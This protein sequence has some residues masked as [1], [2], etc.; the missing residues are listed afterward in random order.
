[1]NPPSPRREQLRARLIEAAET[2][3]AAEG[4][5][6]LRARSL[7]ETVGCAVGAI[8]TVFPDLDGLIL[9]CNGRTL[10]ALDA[11]MRAAIQPDRD[12]AAH[13]EALG[14]A[15]LRFAAAEPRRWRALF[16]H[17]LPEG[18]E[19][20]PW[21]GEQLETV[22]QS[23]REPVARLMPDRNETAREEIAQALFAAVH[24]IV[25]LGLDGKI[26]VVAEAVIADRIRYVVRAALIGAADLPY[27]AA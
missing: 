4:L 2:T 19:L 6:A 25:L 13:L 17:R 16:E 7:A 22:L 10:F 27:P 26:G 9:A 20:P 12:P 18:A 15:Y 14:L 21:Y 3:I 23:L 1:M 8:Y 11:A 5:G 24:G